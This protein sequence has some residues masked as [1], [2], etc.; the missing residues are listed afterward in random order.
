MKHFTSEILMKA[1]VAESVHLIDFETAHVN[2]GFITDTYFLTVSGMKPYANMIVALSPVIYTHQP[3]YWEIQVVGILPGFG[4]SATVPY[5][6]TMQL[7]GFIGTKGISVVGASSSKEIDIY[8]K[9]DD[10]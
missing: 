10:S 5:C 8:G 4:L 7:D 6:V 1:P 2:G 9:S 3:E